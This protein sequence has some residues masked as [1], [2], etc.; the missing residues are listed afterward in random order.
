MLSTVNQN[1]T[2]NFEVTGLLQIKFLQAEHSIKRL[3]VEELTGL[4]V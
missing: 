4:H 1:S 2:L 3:S